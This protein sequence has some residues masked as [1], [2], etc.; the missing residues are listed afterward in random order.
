MRRTEGTASSRTKDEFDDEIDDTSDLN[1]VE[2]GLKMAE[3]TNIAE[4]YSTES[5][6]G[7]T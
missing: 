6:H 5:V 3:K 2:N 7:T 4:C 1:M